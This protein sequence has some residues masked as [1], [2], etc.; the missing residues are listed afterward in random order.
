MPRRAR[1][2]ATEA[3]YHRAVARYRFLTTWC[4]DAPIEQVWEA[5]WDAATWPSWWRGVESSVKLREGDEG[6]VGC[7]WRQ[8][9]RS[10][11]PYT[12]EL[13]SR[14]TRVERPHLIEGS[15]VGALVGE[16]RWRLF[17]GQGTAVTYEWN[18]A[19]TKPW[20]NALAPAGRPL[21]AWNHDA[22]MR[23]GGRGLAR[24]LDARLLA[25]D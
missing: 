22:I 14:T 9:W 10:M 12:L 11:L 7:V 23:E 21:F 4:L 1:Y 6:G 25:Q 24:H 15:A 16:G 17:E 5:I 20:M 8:R 19:T 3:V 18:V 13:E 2:L